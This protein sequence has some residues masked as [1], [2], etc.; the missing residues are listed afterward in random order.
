MLFAICATALREEMTGGHW[1]GQLFP[2]SALQF[3]LRETA[4]C[5][6]NCLPVRHASVLL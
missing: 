2:E 6:P 3:Q 5:R 4:V 1:F